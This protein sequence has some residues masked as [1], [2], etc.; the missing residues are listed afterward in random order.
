MASTKLSGETF[1]VR[2]NP[3]A[4]SKFDLGRPSECREKISGNIVINNNTNMKK[5]DENSRH[6]NS[7]HVSCVLWACM[8]GINV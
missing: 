5:D 7:V 8:E 1:A 2:H 4:V 3:Y 6:L